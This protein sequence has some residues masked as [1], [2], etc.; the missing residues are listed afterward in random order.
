MS[1]PIDGFFSGFTFGIAVV[2]IL[3]FIGFTK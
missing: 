2:L 3:I 1:L